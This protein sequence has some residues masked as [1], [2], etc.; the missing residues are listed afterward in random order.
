LALPRVELRYLMTAWT[1]EL[2][3]E[4]ELLAGVMRAVL[5]HATVPE[6]FQPESLHQLTPPMLRLAST[7][8]APID[9]IKTL[10]GQ[11]K[12]ALDVSVTIDIDLGLER[13]LASPP[14]T[15]DTGVGRFGDAKPVP[16]RRVAGDV[17]VPDCEGVDVVSPHGSAK[18]NAAGRFLISAAPGDEISLLTDPVRTVVVPEQGGV[19][20]G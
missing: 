8:R 16:T 17:T 7:E 5:A 13:P 10:E 14:S 20:I 1:T 11:L 15:I 4:R 9:V 3:D 12:P 6:E 18:V 19:V 2:S